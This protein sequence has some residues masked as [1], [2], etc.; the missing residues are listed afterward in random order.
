MYL[1]FDVFFLVFLIK[2]SGSHFTIQL[3]SSLPI[4]FANYVNQFTTVT[5][6]TPMQVWRAV[7]L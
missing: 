2:S 1:V 5:V 4:V 6:F 7:A 3:I